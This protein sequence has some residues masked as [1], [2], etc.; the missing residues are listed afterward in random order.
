MFFGR[1]K[2]KIQGLYNLSS[3][4]KY[5]LSNTKGNKLYDV[6]YKIYRGIIEEY[7]SK[8]ILEIIEKTYELKLPYRF[9]SIQIIKRKVDVNNLTRFGLNWVESVKNKKQIYH[10][11]N[12]SKGFVYRFKWNKENS[13][14]PN[15][16]FYKFVPSRTN[17]RKL[18]FAIKNK[19]CDYFE[20]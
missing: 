11:N 12:H 16:Y 6:D 15:L 8:M 2:N 9:G 1:S 7:Y 17:K 10:L 5:Y 13:L 3:I 18:A 20:K 14:I 4:Y 19:L